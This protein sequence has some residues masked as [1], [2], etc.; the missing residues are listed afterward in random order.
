MSSGFRLPGKSAA[1]SVLGVARSVRTYHRQSHIDRMVSFYSRFVRPGDLVF[2][3]GAHVGDRTRAFRRL[4]CR[5]LAVEPQP[6]LAR[7]LR[8]LYARSRHT[9]VVNAAV[10]D[11]TASVKLNVNSKNPAV[12]TASAEFIR[13]AQA[14]APGWNGQEWDRELEVAA[15]TLDALIAR[16][17]RPAFMKIDVEGYEDRVLAGLSV[18]LPAFSFEFTTHQKD[19]GLRALQR[20]GNLGH[21]RFNACLGESWVEVFDAPQSEH[22]IAAWLARL[23]AEANSGDIYCQRI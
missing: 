7:L 10:S 21:Y 13:A 19:V 8:L 22:D 23:P 20:I 4:G 17:G 12:S 6:L 3:I 1:A 15:T 11:S 2:D 9:V 5:V 16:Y 18:A 14:G